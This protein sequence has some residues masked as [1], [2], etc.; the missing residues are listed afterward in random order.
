M[1]RIKFCTIFFFNIGLR[2]DSTNN[3]KYAACLALENSSARFV[4]YENQPQ[5]SSC[6]HNCT[7]MGIGM[8]GVKAQGRLSTSLSKEAGVEGG[9]HPPLLLGTHLSQEIPSRSLFFHLHNSTVLTPNQSVRGCFE[10]FIGVGTGWGLGDPPSVFPVC[11]GR[12]GGPSCWIRPLQASFSVSSDIM[13][14][15]ISVYQ[16]KNKP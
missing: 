7:F 16:S 6:E 1:V 13:F 9:L 8:G 12:E 15:I 14:C 2:T 4:D 11:V 3:V 5:I 10:K